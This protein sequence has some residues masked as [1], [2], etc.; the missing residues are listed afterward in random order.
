[1]SIISSFSLF[2]SLSPEELDIL[3]TSMT[4][5]RAGA[6]HLIFLEKDEADAIYFIINGAIRIFK[7]SP[8]GKEVT[9]ALLFEGD[10]FGE[11]GILTDGYRTAGAETLE[12]CD[13]LVLEKERFIGILKEHGEI[14]LKLFKEVSR[15]LTFTNEQLESLINRD[16]QARVKESLRRYEGVRLTHQEIANIVG[17]TRE[18]VS[19]ALLK[20][21]ES[22]EIEYNNK[23]FIVKV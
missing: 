10:F 20:L 16:I 3:E 2:Q 1:M 11:T 7:T 19:R 15:R 22:G 18:S 9:L 6:K 12:P 8:E 17:S 23:R 5:K 4:R 21:Q 14:T 13:L